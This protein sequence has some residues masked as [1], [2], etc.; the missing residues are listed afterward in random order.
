MGLIVTTVILLCIYLL[1]IVLHCCNRSI[2]HM[3][4]AGNSLNNDTR[5]S[6]REERSWKIMSNELLLTIIRNLDPPFPDLDVS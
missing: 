5:C 6:G 2:C 4:Y 1:K 3:A